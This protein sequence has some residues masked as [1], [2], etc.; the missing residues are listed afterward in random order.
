MKERGDDQIDMRSKFRV[1]ICRF[2]QFEYRC[3]GV[4][5][6][7]LITLGSRAQLAHGRH[8]VKQMVSADIQGVTM[9]EHVNHTNQNGIA[10]ECTAYILRIMMHKHTIPSI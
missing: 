8:A 1:D 7:A 9:H 10:A 5:D 4:D 3:N 6:A 2:N